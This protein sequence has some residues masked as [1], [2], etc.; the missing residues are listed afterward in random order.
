MAST[1]LITGATGNVGCEVVKQLSLSNVNIIA[2]TRNPDKAKAKGWKNVEIRTFDY[3]NPDSIAK[4]LE[5]VDKLFLISPMIH[6]DNERRLK[7]TIDLAPKAGVSYIINLAAMGVEHSD[8]P[9]HR[10][11]Q[12]IEKSGIPYTF[13]RPNW[14]M[15]N[16]VTFLRD[17]IV[18]QQGIFLPAGDAKTSFIDIR[19]IAAVAVQVLTK[20]I[21]KNKAY[22]LTGPES[23]DHNQV[24]Q[25]I[26]KISGKSVK[27]VA[28]SEDDT[29]KAL[30]AAGWPEEN[31]TG[32][33]YLYSAVRAGYVAAVA[34]DVKNVLGRDPITFAKFAEDYAER[35]K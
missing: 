6:P 15:Q 5:G 30:L 19:D 14:F 31:V 12:Y 32:M 22:T 4:A 9:M 1:I 27:Y 28:L 13:L 8:N 26:N 29:R 25:K 17:P 7:T 20:D 33:L 2:G 16:F 21:H 35:W 3:D 24:A 11:E 10:V 23:L 18:H 34:P